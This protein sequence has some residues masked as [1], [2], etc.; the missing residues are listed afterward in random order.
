VTESDTIEDPC[1][2]NPREQRPR[3]MHETP[4]ARAE[5]IAYDS[6]FGCWRLCRACANLGRFSHCRRRVEVAR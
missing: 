4:H 6:T 5:I 3:F 2:Y 1:E